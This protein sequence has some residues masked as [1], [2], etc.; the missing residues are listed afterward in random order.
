[1]K[2][3]VFIILT[4]LLYGFAEGQTIPATQS[5][6]DSVISKGVAGIMVAALPTFPGGEK[7]MNQFIADHW[8]LPRSP[9][10]IQGELFAT[11]HFDSKGHIGNIC[12]FKKISG[13]KTNIES[14][15][16]GAELLR[17]IRLM[18]NWIPAEQGDRKI[19][20]DF[21]IPVKLR[22]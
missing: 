10:P 15:P 12:V 18:P 11:L 13:T 4:T 8:Q 9:E 7:L 17:I 6:C 21:T 19:P 2:K 16:L 3:T 14:T 5:C 20:L 22:Y 1:M